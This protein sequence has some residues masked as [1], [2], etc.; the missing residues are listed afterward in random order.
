M[1][2]LTIFLALKVVLSVTEEWDM[3]KYFHNK[4]DFVD[5]HLEC[6]ETTVWSSVW[7]NNTDIHRLGKTIYQAGERTQEIQTLT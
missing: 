1:F 7:D 5:A 3:L 4:M 6:Y 2:W